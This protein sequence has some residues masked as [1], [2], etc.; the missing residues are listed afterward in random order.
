MR[1]Y[2]NCQEAIS[3]ITRD[4]AEMGTEVKIKTMQD[5]I[6]EENDDFVT[7][8][9]Q[10]YSFCILDTSDKDN[11]CHNLEWCQE[12]FN[13]RISKDRINPGLAWKLREE[14][15][16]PFLHFS[17]NPFTKVF[18]ER[19]AYT[20]SERLNNQIA[21][22]IKILQN[23][24]GS[25]QAV[26]PIYSKDIDNRERG[27]KARIP[28]SM[29]YQL[30]IRDGKVDII[31]TMRSCDLFTHARNDIWMACELRDFIAKALKL[32]SGKMFMFISSLH[33]YKKDMRG[34]F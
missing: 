20:Y 3:E 24:H 13:E 15:W 32:P 17:M 26:I 28:C 21:E 25:R 16:K 27:G 33:G 2:K 7:K 23:D 9:I 18:E 5:K 10:A 31:Y 19:F 12:E 29:F 11:I 34:V 1:I 6:V 8:E 14:V 30:Q 22:V 4:L